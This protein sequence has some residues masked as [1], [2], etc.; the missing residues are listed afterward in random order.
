MPRPYSVSSKAVM[1]KK[2][3]HLVT[4][5]KTED[6]TEKEDIQKPDLLGN[7]LEA[8]SAWSVFLEEAAKETGV[9][10]K[11][12]AADWPPSALVLGLLAGE[13]WSLA[14]RI[15]EL[16]SQDRAC[17]ASTTGRPSSPGPSG[18]AR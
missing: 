4:K 15:Q 12:R 1:E 13:G 10:R 5:S 7:S 8:S 11:D 2:R 3:K 9:R 16:T 14:C 18:S 17:G 6:V